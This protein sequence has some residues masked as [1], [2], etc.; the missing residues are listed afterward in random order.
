MTLE[1]YLKKN[2]KPE[3]GART[4]LWSEGN[5]DEQFNDGELRG[6]AIALKDIADSLGV[7]LPPL[8]EQDFDD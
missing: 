2:Y 3:D 4:S 5:G 6:Q 7:I 1:E 8:A